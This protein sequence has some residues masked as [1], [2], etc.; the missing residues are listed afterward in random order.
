[1]ACNALRHP[2]RLHRRDFRLP[3]PSTDISDD[4]HNYFGLRIWDCGL[5]YANNQ[6]EIRIPR[7]AIF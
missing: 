4:H 2:S 1:M 5:I 3:W 7:S 6:S